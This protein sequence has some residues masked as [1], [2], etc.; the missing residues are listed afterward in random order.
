MQWLQDNLTL[1]RDT[2]GDSYKELAS[3]IAN[4]SDIPP[5]KIGLAIPIVAK[6][7]KTILKV[8]DW[9]TATAE[10]LHDRDTIHKSMIMMIKAGVS[11][12]TA[13]KI[14]AEEY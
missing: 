5:S 2:S 6:N 11:L 4:N 8:D 9:N 7:I 10:Q 13:M 3:Q 1:N 14:V 12:N